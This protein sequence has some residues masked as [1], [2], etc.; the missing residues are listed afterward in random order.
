MAFEFQQALKW[1]MEAEGTKIA[2]LVRSTG[3]SRDVLN[4]LLKRPDVTTSV[5][6]AILI[7]SFYGKTVNEFVQRQQAAD[8]DKAATLFGLLTPEERNMLAAQVRGILN[9]RASLAS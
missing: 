9:A 8:I 6:N 4:K 7:A 3:V 2:D 1:H 5:E